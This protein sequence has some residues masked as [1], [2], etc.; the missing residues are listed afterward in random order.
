M[1]YHDIYMHILTC[2][3]NLHCVLIMFEFFVMSFSNRSEKDKKIQQLFR[4]TKLLH[5]KYKNHRYIVIVLR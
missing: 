1:K 2:N 4:D 3:R 5:N